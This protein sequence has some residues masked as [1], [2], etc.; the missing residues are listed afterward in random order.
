M[1]IVL[2]LIAAAGI[3]FSGCNNESPVKTDEQA[4]SLSGTYRGVFRPEADNELMR[5]EL[6]QVGQRIDGVLL[7]YGEKSNSGWE[8][9]PQVMK[10][11][12]VISDGILWLAIAAD[13][14][15]GIMKL[16]PTPFPS[17]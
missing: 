9:P 3:L 15:F 1:R 16:K 8:E 10:M 5:L 4:G 11:S 17:I 12:G 2:M 14:D 7:H 13:P 6:N